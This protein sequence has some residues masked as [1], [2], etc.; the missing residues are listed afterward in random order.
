MATSD[1]ASRADMYPTLDAM[2]V[3][4]V[5]DSNAP[6]MY[7]ADVSSEAERIARL[8]RRLGFRVIDA[9]LRELSK[10]GVIKYLRENDAPGGNA[11]WY[12]GDSA[13]GGA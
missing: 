6:P 13:G 4:A 5:S 8:I 9:R 1:H 11:G 2:I 12:L 3:K 7:Q 10:A